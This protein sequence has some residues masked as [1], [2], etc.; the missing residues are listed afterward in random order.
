MTG[1][2]DKSLEVERVTFAGIYLSM[3]LHSRGKKRTFWSG[4]STGIFARASNGCDMLTAI[5]TFAL[6]VR[7]ARN[8]L[9]QL[10]TVPIVLSRISKILVLAS[11]I[12]SFDARVLFARSHSG[13]G[14]LFQLGHAVRHSPPPVEFSFSPAGNMMDS[15]RDSHAGSEDIF[16][17]SAL[18]Q[19]ALREFSLNLVEPQ[20]EKV[21]GKTPENWALLQTLRKWGINAEHGLSHTFSEP[22]WSM[23]LQYSD[24]FETR[25]NPER[26]GHGMSVFFRYSFRK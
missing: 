11:C 1:V 2:H 19:S 22:Q 8:V 15:Q 18:D 12:G 16:Q 6:K 21:E 7:L 5:G 24:I 26:G 3:V 4:P 14:C 10:K 13:D 25:S 23:A 20:M 17:F 9:S